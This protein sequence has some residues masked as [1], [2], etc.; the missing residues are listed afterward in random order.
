MLV[1]ICRDRDQVAILEPWDP[2]SEP[3]Y[4]EPLYSQNAFPLQIREVLSEKPSRQTLD[5]LVA[6]VACSNGATQGLKGLEY[7]VVCY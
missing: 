5:I 7:V 3:D 4:P 2:N 6:I 1:E